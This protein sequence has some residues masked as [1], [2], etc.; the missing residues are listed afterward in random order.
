V[1][2]PGSTVLVL[3]HMVWD[4]YDADRAALRDEMFAR[5]ELPDEIDPPA[6]AAPPLYVPALDLDATATPVPAA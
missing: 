1:L 2:V 6:A 5:I 3:Y 4:A